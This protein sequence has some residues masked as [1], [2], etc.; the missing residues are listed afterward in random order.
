MMRIATYN[1]LPLKKKRKVQLKPGGKAGAPWFFP[2]MMVLLG[3][4]FVVFAVFSMLSLAAKFKGCEVRD[5][6]EINGFLVGLPTLLLSLPA[7]LFLLNCL[8]YLI[9]PARRLTDAYVD[10]EDR[11]GF[12]ESQKVMITVFAWLSLVTLPLIALGF[13]L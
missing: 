13:W 7:L 1:P 12:W 8:I 2:V 4:P 3:P 9:P 5:L 6:P 10:R 11:P